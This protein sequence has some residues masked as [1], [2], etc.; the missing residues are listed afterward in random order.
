[1][2]LGCGQLGCV[3]L[4]ARPAAPPAELFATGLLHDL[5][6]R[7]LQLGPPKTPRPSTAF[8][9]HAASP[10]FSSRHCSDIG[11]SLSEMLYQHSKGTAVL[12]DASVVCLRCSMCW[13][14]CWGR[15][16]GRPVA[17]VLQLGL[18]MMLVLGQG[19]GQGGGQGC[20][21]A[22]AT[23]KLHLHQPCTIQVEYINL[24]H[25]HVSKAIP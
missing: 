11:I 10:S 4:F 21:A 12:V 15:E 17:P 19:G 3:T 1:V 9:C 18:R 13:C 5:H 14:S 20:L 7:S 25:L 2:R 16:M 6:A 23:Q 22:H 24:I 8:P